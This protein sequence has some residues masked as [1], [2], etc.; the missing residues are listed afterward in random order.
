VNG[1][2]EF[3]STIPNYIEETDT[4]IPPRWWNWNWGHY[5]DRLRIT[6]GDIMAEME[7]ETGEAAQFAFGAELE[8]FV[9][10]GQFDH[11]HTGKAT[12]DDHDFRLTVGRWGIYIAVRGRETSR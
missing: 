10:S 11:S 1:L 3:L 8:L 4:D 6:V 2:R 9:G 5:G 7:S 12:F